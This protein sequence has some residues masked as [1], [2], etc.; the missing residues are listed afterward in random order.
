MQARLHVRLDDSAELQQYRPLGL[1]HYIE[2]VPGNQRQDYANNQGDQRFIAHQRLS[3]VR[4]SGWRRSVPARAPRS[5]APAP[6]IALGVALPR[7]SIILSS[8]R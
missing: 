4:S 7:L 5:L 2:A 1:R 6:E 3:L 8:G